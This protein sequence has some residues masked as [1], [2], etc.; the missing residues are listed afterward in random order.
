M[1]EAGFSFVEV[2]IRG[3]RRS[4]SKDNV[5]LPAVV[6][7]A[8]RA[9]GTVIEDGPVAALAVFGGYVGVPAGWAARRHRVPIVVHEQNAV[10]G[11]A[12]RLVARMAKRVLAAFPLRRRRLA[13]HVEVVGNPLRADLASFDRNFLRATARSRYGLDPDGTVVGVLGG[14]LGAGAL[15]DAV[16]AAATEGFGDGGV[17]HLT[18]P[19]H[20]GRISAMAKDVPW[21]HPIGFEPD[22]Q[23][24][25]AASD[26][27]LSRAGALTISELAATGSPAVVV[28][29]PAGRGY[30]EDNAA[31]LL[32]AGGCSIIDQ[33]D[34][35][36]A[37]DEIR[38]LVGDQ[39]R[40]ER[41]SR[42]AASTAMPE[43]A[44]RVA[45]AMQEEAGV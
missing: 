37:I 12:N 1:P 38:A 30:Q 20:F 40:R 10:P 26:V 14:S 13:G 7:R 31:V 27:V 43:A 39:A 18:G 23:H 4:A 42:A 21:W 33:S 44:E 35:G 28:P 9:I 29:L 15:N 5:T 19:D 6:A 34:I 24:F 41:M 16:V 32:S 8:A 22:M 11:L 17:L 2:E 3:L 25:Y 45:D 36:A